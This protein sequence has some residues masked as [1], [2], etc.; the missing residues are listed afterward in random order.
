L[1]L[2]INTFTA[3]VESPH[4]SPHFPPRSADSPAG[5]FDHATST[6]AGAVNHLSI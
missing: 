3:G 1:I 5:I 4:I 6:I 2:F